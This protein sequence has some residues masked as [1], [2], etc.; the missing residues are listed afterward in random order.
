MKLTPLAKIVLVVAALGAIV[1]VYRARRHNVPTAPVA[2]PPD[3][4]PV[5]GKPGALDG[6]LM[7]STIPVGGPPGCADKPEVRLVLGA[8]NAHAGLLLATGGPQAVAASAMC[9]MGVNLK[10]EHEERTARVLDRLVDGAQLAIV[11]GDGAAAFIRDLNE[12]L[13]KL[14]PDRDVVIVATFGL[15]LGEDKLMGPP[16]WR[17]D[18]QAARGGVVA[19]HAH[20]PAWSVT[21]KWLADNDI[22]LNADAKKYDPQALNWVEAADAADAVAK[23]ESGACSERKNAATGKAESHC[24]Q[25][26][27]VRTPADAAVAAGKGG[28]VSVVSTRE[29]RAA[30]P[31]LLVG[32]RGWTTHNRAV[33]RSLVMAAFAGGTRLAVDPTAVGPAAA[34]SKLVYGE[35]TGGALGA[36]VRPSTLTD[37]GGLAVE[38]GGWAAMGLAENL[39]MFGMLPGSRNMFEASYTFFADLTESHPGEQA[40]AYPPARTVF[41]GAILRELANADPERAQK[42][43]LVKFSLDDRVGRVVSRRAWTIPFQPDS[44]RFTA[45]AL[46]QLDL[47]MRDLLIAGGLLIEVHA[48]TTDEKL[49]QAQGQAVKDWLESSSPPNF[50]TGRVRIVAHGQKAGE[51]EAMKPKIEIVLATRAD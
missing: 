43:E 45:E 1:L 11:P 22:P 40:P 35:A 27:A 44:A 17:D 38:V 3:G 46:P 19:G 28:L 23:Y 7:A 49:A 34:I 13:A 41:D 6:G 20:E 29:Y 50:P 15:S 5:A 47:L 33:V 36:H 42:P 9:A 16:A 30:T 37:K 4:I 24:V 32:E 14:G 12:R 8:A 25:G 10:L 2:V 21:L 18:P 48:Y 39:E 51:P 31:V 26:V